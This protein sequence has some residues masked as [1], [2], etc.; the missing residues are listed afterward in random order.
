[1]A[2]LL[3]NNSLLFSNFR[4]LSKFVQ[5]L[6]SFVLAIFIFLFFL[7]GRFLVWVVICFGSQKHFFQLFWV[8]VAYFECASVE[9]LGCG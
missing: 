3:E 9:F 4:V 5:Y 1:M 8:F 7:I 6:Q 2:V